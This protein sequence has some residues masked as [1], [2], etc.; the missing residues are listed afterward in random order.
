MSAY[1]TALRPVVDHLGDRRV[2]SITKDDIETVVQ[3]SQRGQKPDGYVAGAREAQRQE[4]AVTVVARFYQ[5][6]ARAHAQRV[7]RLGG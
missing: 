7:H 2:Q 4:D 5:S 1:V 3:G 6:D